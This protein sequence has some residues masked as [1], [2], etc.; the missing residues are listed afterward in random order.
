VR[1]RKK[2][3]I[4]SEER[5][6]FERRNRRNRARLIAPAAL[7]AF[8]AGG[9]PGLADTDDQ[10]DTPSA[11]DGTT[12]PAGD[13]IFQAQGRL[14]RLAE[15]PDADVRMRVAAW[16]PG[17][18]EWMTDME[19]VR[20]IT[21]WAT[22]PSPAVRLALARALAAAPATLGLWSVLEHLSFDTD[23]LVRRAVTEA[24]WLRRREAPERLS[25]VLL[26]LADDIDPAT[27]AIARHSLGDG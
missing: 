3:P 26:R 4:S 6:A 22:S 11:D 24:A 9:T 7:A 15:H 27:R 12:D 8:L 20:L 19:R 13:A 5:R 2:D 25:R 16:L 10:D 18:L 23:A 21:D 14:R 1:V 17:A